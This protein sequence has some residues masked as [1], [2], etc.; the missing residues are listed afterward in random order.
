[1]YVAICTLKG[2]CGLVVKA[3]GW[4]SLDR[5]TSARIRWR[6]RGVASDAVPEP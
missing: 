3:A 1:M 4:L 5:Q 2:R 6:P